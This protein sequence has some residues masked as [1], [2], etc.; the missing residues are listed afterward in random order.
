MKD[1]TEYPV[2]ASIS[3]SVIGRV[4][5][6]AQM[7]F[8][9]LFEVIPSLSYSSRNVIFALS[10]SIYTVSARAKRDRRI[11]SVLTR[12]LLREK[13]LLTPEYLNLFFLLLDQ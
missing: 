11:P 3:H 13:N 10:G 4:G 2:V 5:Q 12:M 9:R 1:R 6:D 7:R 8:I